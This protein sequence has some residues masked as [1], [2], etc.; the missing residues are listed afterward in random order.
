[1][2]WGLLL[3][4]REHTTFCTF[5]SSVWQVDFGISGKL[6]SVSS[7]DKVIFVYVSET[8][9]V[10]SWKNLSKFSLLMMCLGNS[11]LSQ[12]LET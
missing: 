2:G 12:L 1:M 8:S 4:T 6:L 5:V 9:Y 7:I 3:D 11:N 10:K